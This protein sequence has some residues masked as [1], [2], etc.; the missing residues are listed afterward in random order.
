MKRPPSQP[1][2]PELALQA[3][4]TA[5]KAE[6]TEL[7]V[8]MEA[9]TAGQAALE[10]KVDK[11]MGQLKERDQLI[12]RLQKQ[13]FGPSS[14][15][16]P[17]LIDEQQAML[18]FGQQTMPSAAPAEATEP[19]ATPPAE[20]A[21]AA[22]AEPKKPRKPYTKL[23]FDALGLP[24]HVEIRLP[25]A[26]EKNPELY[27]KI[28]VEETELLILEKARYS[29][30]VIQRPKYVLITPPKPSAADEIIPNAPILAPLAVLLPH[31][32]ASPSLVAHIAVSRFCD[33]LPYHRQSQMMERDGIALPASQM[34]AWLGKIASGFL[35]SIHRAI[36]EYALAANVLGADETPV[37]YLPDKQ[38]FK[39]RQQPA[40]PALERPPPEATATANDANAE[41]SP[42]SKQGY[43]WVLKRSGL[44]AYFHWAT[45]RSADV[46]QELL[47]AQ[48][49]GALITDDYAAY[50]REI[51]RRAA[52]PMEYGKITRA[53]CLAHVRRK[54][55]EIE[56]YHPREAKKALDEI[57]RLYA[58]EKALRNQ[59]ATPQ[60]IKATRQARS[61]PIVERLEQYLK[62]LQQNGG[63]LPKDSLMKA[64]SYALNQMPAMQPYLSDSRVSIDN[65]GT[66]N[67]IRP[68]AIG[69]KNWLFMGTAESGKTAAIYYS[70]IETAKLHGLDPQRY[71]HDLLTAMPT[72]KN[73]ELPNWTPWAYAARMKLADAAKHAPEEKS[74][75]A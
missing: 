22:T 51:T 42:T 70:I 25:E 2:P 21:T 10:A 17:P 7:K 74:D 37:K 12:E 40:A 43:F 60:Q 1:S 67:A 14:E 50:Q 75:A 34:G 72:M 53:A 64:V 41:T 4:Y 55:S 16:R 3:E 71:L 28:G 38:R 32:Y 44:A 20:A 68:T 29:V 33:H 5:L 61:K 24:R 52:R 13:L 6:N 63:Y 56:K 30:L 11:L 57:A 65:N 15:K 45:S 47:P 31:S 59:A 27:R 23:R 73:D 48:W 8:K 39:R 46:L 49:S 54:F 66:E 36:R 58:I 35:Q 19:G 9:V 62:E 69:K 18:N 26:V